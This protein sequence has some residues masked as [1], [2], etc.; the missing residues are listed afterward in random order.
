MTSTNPGVAKPEAVQGNFGDHGVVGYH[1]G[2][3]SVQRL[4][5]VRELRPARVPGVHGDEGG[6]GG[7]QGYLHPLEHEPVHPGHQRVVDG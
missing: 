4:Q 2:N 1:H 7:L 5:V 6:A 3:G